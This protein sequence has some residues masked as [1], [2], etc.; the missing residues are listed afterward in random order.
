MLIEMKVDRI[1][2]D[3]LFNTPIVILKDIS[4]KHSLPIWVGTF[5]AQAIVFGIN[6]KGLPRPLPYDIMKVL[7]EKIELTLEK[8][9]VSDLQDN[10]FYAVIELSRN[11][12]KIRIDSRPSD[13]IALAVRIGCPILVSDAVIKKAKTI[14]ISKDRTENKQMEVDES[15]HDREELKDWLEKLKPEDFGEYEM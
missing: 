3:P 13:A 9:I 8:V 2:I 1:T 7:L 15:I 5:E 4:N 11:G 6:K 12:Q 14:D 10:T